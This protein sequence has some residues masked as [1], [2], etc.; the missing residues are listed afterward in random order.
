LRGLVAAAMTLLTLG[1]VRADARLGSSGPARI[2]R[3]APSSRCGC[4]PP[5]I[6]TLMVRRRS[7]GD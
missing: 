5:I 1:A 3:R 7:P 2:A 4:A 6:R